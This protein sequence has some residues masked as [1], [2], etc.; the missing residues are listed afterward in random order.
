MTAWAEAG[1][2]PASGVTSPMSLTDVGD[3]G[4]GGG[5]D[6]GG[7]E[8]VREGAAAW[9]EA[10]AAFGRDGFSLVEGAREAEMVR[11]AARAK[12]RAAWWATAALAAMVAMM[13][14]MSA[15]EPGPR[16]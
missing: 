2:R 1:R 9:P 4:C 7:G 3:G 10:T 11:V 8:G 14:I 12:A 13:V 15:V 6:E 16:C 5:G